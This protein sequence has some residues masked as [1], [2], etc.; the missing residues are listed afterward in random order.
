MNIALLLLTLTS[1]SNVN[2]LPDGLLDSVCWVESSYRTEVDNPQDGGSPSIGVCEI[3]YTTAQQVGFQYVENLY[4]PKV[5]IKYAAAY[6]KHQIDRY[7]G[8][9]P[10]AISA[11]NAGSCKHYENGLIKN[12]KYVR[13][14]YK[15]WKHLKEIQNAKLSASTK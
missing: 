6:L 13:K 4:N 12:A 5:N 1:Y 11:Y 7:D 9:L 2:G 8:D 10:S 15:T 3:K 14:V